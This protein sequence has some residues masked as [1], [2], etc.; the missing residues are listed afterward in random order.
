LEGIVGRIFYKKNI[1][2]DE[3]GRFVKGKI[4]FEIVTKR[5]Q[6]RLENGWHS[7][8]AK[9]NISEGQKANLELIE[10]RRKIAKRMG[11]NN[12]GKTRTESVKEIVGLSSKERWKNPMFR[13]KM[14]LIY[15]SQ[16]NKELQRIGALRSIQVLKNKRFH[17]T[18]PELEMQKILDEI[19]VTY[20]HPYPVWNIEHKYPADFYIPETNTILEV[21]GKHWHNYPNGSEIDKIRNLELIEKGY[22]V[23]RFWENEFTEKEIKEALQC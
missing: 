19:G 22:K 7:E 2:R 8:K 4:E 5:N 20:I 11:L 17:N 23:L 6:T 9:K 10:S 14:E 21:D 3:K 15:S 16:K 12:L 18:K 1:M 13:A